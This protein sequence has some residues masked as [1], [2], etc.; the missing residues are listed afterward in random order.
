[1]NPLPHVISGN[2][3]TGVLPIKYASPYSFRAAASQS[4]LW[5]DDAT[6]EPFVDDI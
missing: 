1:M 6:T 2:G 5:G 3:L 4:I